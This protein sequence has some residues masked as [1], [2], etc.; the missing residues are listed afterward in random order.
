MAGPPYTI[1]NKERVTLR[2]HLKFLPKSG[3][4][5]PVN[6]LIHQPV[7]FPK[8]PVEAKLHTLNVLLPA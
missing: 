2:R 3:F 6:Q 7:F 8:P 5:F 4:R 1:F